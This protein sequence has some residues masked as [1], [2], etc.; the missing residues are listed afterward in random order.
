LTSTRAKT[1]SRDGAVAEPAS[2]RDPAGGVVHRSGRIFR[3]LRA[4][5]APV[6]HGLLDEAWFAALVESGAVI[7]SRRV[8]EQEVPDLYK[9]T[10]DVSLV[11]EHPKIDFISYAYEWPFEMLK[12]AAQL[13]M[14]VTCHA[15]AHGYMVKDATPFNVQFVGAAPIFIDVASFERHE[16]G[17]SWRAY[18][19]FCRLF[20]NP[21]LLQAYTGVPFQPW[22]R[23]SLD[24]LDTEH[25]RRLLPLRAKL[26]RGVFLDVV[27]QSLLNRR[28]AASE[29]AAQA[30]SQ[31]AISPAVIRGLLDRMKRTVAGLKRPSVKSTWSDYEETK[32][33]YSAAAERFKE[34]FVRDALAQAQPGRVWDL[35]CNKGQFS[36]IAADYAEYVIAMDSDEASVGGL[37][38]RVAHNRHNVLPLVVDLLNPSPIRAGRKR[39]AWVS[40][41]A[42]TATWHSA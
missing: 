32:S 12:A 13:Q 10:D 4:E 17:G 42:V 18:S 34:S 22:L 5:A 6:L 14:E 7:D 33:H 25:L 36:L 19:Q 28:L 35:G 21:L 31:G 3:Y 38:E 26:R 24:G 41:H 37:Y 1:I 40:Q 15:F 29:Q 8:A 30:L 23:G 27:L 39:S 9:H 16:E 11:V 2:F 20:L